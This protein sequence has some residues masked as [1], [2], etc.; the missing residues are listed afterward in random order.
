MKCPSASTAAGFCGE[1]EQTVY[2]A[3]HRGTLQP[4]FGTSRHRAHPE[5]EA[6]ILEATRRAPTS[7][8]THWS[9]RKLGA[10]LDVSHMMVARVWHKHGLQPHRIERYMASNDPHFEKKAADIIGC[11]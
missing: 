9:T 10:H 1:L 7:G 2:R 6:R 11:T 4:A 5:L 3:A 8:A